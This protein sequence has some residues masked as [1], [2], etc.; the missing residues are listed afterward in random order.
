MG[1]NKYSLKQ[2][3]QKT[4][5]FVNTKKK[6]KQRTES[7]NNNKKKARKWNKKA[8]AAYS[9]QIVSNILPNE[10]LFFTLTIS[11]FPVLI[12]RSF[13]FRSVST[14]R[15]QLEARPVRQLSIFR[16]FRCCN[17]LFAGI[18]LISWCVWVQRGQEKDRLLVSRP[19][20]DANL[21]RPIQPRAVFNR[22]ADEV[23][24]RRENS[25]GFLA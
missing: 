16:W 9:F 25:T 12:A 22:Y 2:L 24:Q 21:R 23:T 6:W 14:S 10:F 19:F 8:C 5:W 17:V 13:E 7:F 4:K 15:Y 11:R 20:F 1:H 3:L 18:Q